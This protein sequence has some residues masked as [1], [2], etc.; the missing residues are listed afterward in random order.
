[1]TSGQDIINVG[2]VLLVQMAPSNYMSF[3]SV[4]YMRNKKFTFSEKRRR[5]SSLVHHTPLPYMPI[6]E[7]IVA[8][9]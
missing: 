6:T 7:F 1:M 3:I 9:S 4:A 5:H 2:Q 8:A